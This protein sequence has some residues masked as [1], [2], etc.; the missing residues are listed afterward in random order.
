M[1]DTDILTFGQGIRIMIEIV[2]FIILYFVYLNLTNPDKP[3]FIDLIVTSGLL[4]L[5]LFSIAIIANIAISLTVPSSREA[6]V[7]R[8]DKYQTLFP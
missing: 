1:V 6:P 3:F 2:V 5:W 8:M 7:S 4:A